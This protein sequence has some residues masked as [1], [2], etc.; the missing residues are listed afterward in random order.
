MELKNLAKLLIVA[1]MISTILW[2][3]HPPT[4]YRLML[5]VGGGWISWMIHAG[6]ELRRRRLQ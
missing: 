1:G 3:A 4:G 2:L 5:A 6:I